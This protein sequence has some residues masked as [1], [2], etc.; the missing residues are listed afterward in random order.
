M[1]KK[2]KNKSILLPSLKI[3]LDDLSEIIKLIKI[4][5]LGSIKILDE[6]DNIIDIDEIKKDIIFYLTIEVSAE[7]KRNDFKICFRRT[8]SSI[9][10]YYEIDSDNLLF[11]LRIEKMIKGKR[12]FII[13][14]RK[15][16]LIQGIITL[17][18]MIFASLSP[19]IK[20]NNNLILNIFGGMLFFLMAFFY[21][22][23]NFTV[24]TIIILKEVSR[25]R[26]FYYKHYS[27]ISFA[28]AILIPIIIFGIL[29]I[30][31]KY[32]KH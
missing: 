25:I 21:F 24:D 32:S 6:K 19:L 1:I 2:F 20:I 17:V 28:K 4:N 5:N 23:S 11:I 9:F 7:N 10:Y 8:N 27:I 18:F 3:T 30:T 26:R 15:S 12:I 16:S 31:D 29:F 13:P 22:F 14:K